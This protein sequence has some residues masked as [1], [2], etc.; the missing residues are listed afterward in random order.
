MVTLTGDNKIAQLHVYWDQGSIMKQIGLLP[1]SLF[2]KANN[3]ET[4]L[5]IQGLSIAEGLLS[6]PVSDFA[7]L[8]KHEDDKVKISSV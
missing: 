7:T 5:P 3:S 6:G 1:T 4:V 8:E 2:C